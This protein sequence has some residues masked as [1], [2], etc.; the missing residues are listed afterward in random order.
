MKLTTHPVAQAPSTK[1]PRLMWHKSTGTIYLV[2][3]MDHNDFAVNLESC[4]RTE[5]SLL[6]G[7]IEELPAGYSVTLTNE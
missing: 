7:E 2:R 1:W 3:S 5:I 6:I 4:V